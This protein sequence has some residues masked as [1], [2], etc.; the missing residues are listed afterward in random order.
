MKAGKRGLVHESIGSLGEEARIFR[1]LASSVEGGLQG[2]SITSESRLKED[3][4]FD[5]ISYLTLAV[6]IAEEYA[7]DVTRDYE[8]YYEVRTVG[9]LAEFVNGKMG[10]TQ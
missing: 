3:L 10:C 5:S 7:L 4:C 8:D 1:L 6:R 2:L 9:D